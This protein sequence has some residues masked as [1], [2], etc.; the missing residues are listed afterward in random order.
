[1]RPL[2]TAGAITFPAPSAAVDGTFV[3]VNG[4]VLTD[5]DVTA[6]VSFH[7]RRAAEATI[8]LTR[9]ADPSAF[10]V[11]PTDDD[12][13]VLAFVEKPPRESA[14]TDLINAGSYV[15]ETTVLERI[16]EGRSSIER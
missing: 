14:P 16:P 12:G 15:L 9:V 6:L 5:L 13:R 2:V 10:G 8:A 1:P 7:R 3:V 4:D 11:V